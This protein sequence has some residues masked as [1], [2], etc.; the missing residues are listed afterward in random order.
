[1]LTRTATS[2]FNS[3][4]C[5]GLVALFTLGLQATLG[6]TSASTA[7]AAETTAKTQSSASAEASAK[8]PAP[9]APAGN[10]AVSAETTANSAKG[11]TPTAEAPIADEW[12]PAGEHWTDEESAKATAEASRRYREG[13]YAGA[14]ALYSRLC[15]K[16]KPGTA[17]PN[18]GLSHEQRAEL[19]A[20]LGTLQ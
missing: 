17:M 19:V 9:P 10:P 15:E 16:L 20:W 5:W 12:G 4:R 2:S 14:A 7:Q 18:L 3:T 6:L 11:E 13:D 8:P 1:M